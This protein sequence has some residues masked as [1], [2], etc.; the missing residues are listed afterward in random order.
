MLL[1][2]SNRVFD[3][4]AKEPYLYK[5]NQWFSYDDTQSFKQKV[6]LLYLKEKIFF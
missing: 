5:N 3:S 4:T 1:N 2:G 6:F